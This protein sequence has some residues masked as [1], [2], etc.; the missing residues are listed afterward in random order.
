[1]VMATSLLRSPA[2]I[3]A[4]QLVVQVFVAARR[5]VEAARSLLPA[6]T[7]MRTKPLAP[8]SGMFAKLKATTEKVL[9][10]IIDSQNQITLRQEAM[11][12]MSE[13]IHSIKERLKKASVE[14][15]EIAARATQYLAE[16]EAQKAVAAKTRAETDQI[17]FATLVRKLRLIM[18]AELLMESGDV[19]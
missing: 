19:Q 5:D 12:V 17:E 13:A 18:A 1:V 15:E 8:A 4:M 6:P 11:S 14:N 9:D 10:A 7:S 2:A 3:Q 16:A